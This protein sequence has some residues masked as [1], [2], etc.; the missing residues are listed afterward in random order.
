MKARM[1]S[2]VVALGLSG[3]MTTAWADTVVVVGASS[4]ATA[5]SSE[6]LAALY[7]MRLKSLPGAG[8]VQLVVVGST[9]AQLFGFLGKTEDQIKAIWA[10]N[11]FSGSASPPI[12]VATP[13]DARKALGNPNA[14]AVVDAASVDASMKVV[15]KL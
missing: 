8:A 5:V 11:L 13:A 14:I 3:L 4:P 12:D 2:T 10:R 15:G 9:K 7:T 6:Q 1:F